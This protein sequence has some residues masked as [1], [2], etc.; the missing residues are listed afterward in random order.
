VCIYLASK[1][2]V[3]T[4]TWTVSVVTDRSTMQLNRF[5]HVFDELGQGYGW[6]KLVTR[7]VVFDPRYGCVPGNVLLLRFTVPV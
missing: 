3:I 4:G 7:T 6:P 1:A 5:T 2:T